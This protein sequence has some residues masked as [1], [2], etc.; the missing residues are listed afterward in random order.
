M[1]LIIP[2]DV[3]EEVTESGDM[4]LVISI[5]GEAGVGE[6]LVVNVGRHSARVPGRNQYRSP[7]KVSHSLR[8]MV[9]SLSG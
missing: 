9:I 7:L 4:K 6:S 5:H 2:E 1:Y 8:K 3:N